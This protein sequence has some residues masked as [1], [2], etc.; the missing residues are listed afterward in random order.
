M[1]VGGDICW[2]KESRGPQAGRRSL[3]EDGGVEGAVQAR[4]KFI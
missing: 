3:A 4:Q 1:N 2:T